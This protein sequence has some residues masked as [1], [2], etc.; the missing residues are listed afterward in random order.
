MSTLW[1]EKVSDVDRDRFTM[2]K[3]VISDMSGTCAKCGKLVVIDRK[4]AKQ[5]LTILC[6]LYTAEIYQRFYF[7]ED[8]SE[9][10]IKEVYR[11][12]KNRRIEKRI[13]KTEKNRRPR[14]SG[15]GRQI[16]KLRQEI[17]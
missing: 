10:S 13:C 17:A 7:S 11:F 15:W 1:H 12:L 8:Q 2:N 4:G 3:E 14:G 6:L 9:I 16:K 5:G